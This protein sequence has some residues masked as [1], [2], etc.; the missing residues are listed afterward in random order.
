LPSSRFLGLAT[1]GVITGSVAMVALGVL[2]VIHV[3]P[4]RTAVAVTAT[5]VYLPAHLW[6]TFH[7]ARG[8]RPPGADWTLAAMVVVI[9]AVLPVVGVQWLGALYPLGA[10]VLLVLRPPWSFVVFGVLLAVP[11]P[12]AFAYGQP[13]WAI[14]FTTGMAL[15][16][17]VLAVPVWLIATARDLRSARARLAEEAVVRERVR[18]EA[19]LHETL[20][21]ALETIAETGDRAVALF[22]QAAVAEQLRAVVGAAR[23]TLS[24]AR[25]M[26]AGWRQSPARDELD[27]A[28]ALLRAAGIDAELRL[29][30]AGVS[31]S[32][33]AVLHE[34][35]ARLL[36]DG[37]AARCVVEVSAAGGIRVVTGE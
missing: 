37:A 15:T 8:D 31:A 16:G 7:I 19:E 2:R 24:T 14:Y 35:V 13:E 21:T 27:T 25:R 20:G 17:L 6:H 23:T 9:A 28:V 1:A 10:S 32:Q 22:P 34:Q 11:T 3:D 18:V 33:L 26:N 4:S 36:Q 12:V 29:P 5:A 30:V